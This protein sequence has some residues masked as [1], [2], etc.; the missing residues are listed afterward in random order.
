MD[1]GVLRQSKRPFF[2]EAKYVEDSRTEDWHVHVP[3]HRFNEEHEIIHACLLIIFL[4][5]APRIVEDI[6]DTWDLN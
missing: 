4:S 5:T 3:L 6:T 2:K 1:P